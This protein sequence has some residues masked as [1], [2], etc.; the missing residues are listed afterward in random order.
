MAPPPTSKQQEALEFLNDLDSFSAPPPPASSAGTTSAAANAHAGTTPPGDTAEV[1]AFLDEITQKSS[2]PLKAK[3]SRPGSRAATERVTLSG[4]RSHN[5]SPRPTSSGATASSN[6]NSPSAE[7]TAGPAGGSGW[8]WGSVWSTASAAIQQAKTAVDE[9]VKNLPNV[10]VPK[11]EQAKKWSAGVMEYVKNAQLDKIGSF[12]ALSSPVGLYEFTR[13][14]LFLGQDITR[15]GLS[16]L[17]DI[18]NA[19]APP[20]AEHEVI[21]V[22]LSHDMEGYDGVETLVYR[23]LSRVSSTSS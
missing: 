3:I 4:T 11:N 18:L 7:S 12:S 13:F 6:A 20:I 21:Q 23:A 2:E 15:S 1:L 17:T 8:G 16:A 22:W 19:V 5:E 14:R 10:P 9:G